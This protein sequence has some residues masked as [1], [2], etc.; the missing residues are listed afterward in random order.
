MGKNIKFMGP[1][2]AGQNTKMVNQILIASTMVG[3]CEGMLYAYKAG[4]DPLLVIE[5]VGAGAAGSW[6][7]NNLGPRIVK[8][9]FEPGCVIAMRDILVDCRNCKNAKH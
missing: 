3:V 7:I 6:S 2:G 4:L 1:A 8:G 9:N 5:A